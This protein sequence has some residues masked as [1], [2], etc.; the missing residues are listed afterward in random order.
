MRKVTDFLKEHKK[1]K[2]KVMILGEKHCKY[3]KETKLYGVSIFP[4]RSLLP[5]ELEE[6]E[7][8]K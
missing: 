2:N 7:T 3:A 1:L 6:V 5:H 4:L 8:R